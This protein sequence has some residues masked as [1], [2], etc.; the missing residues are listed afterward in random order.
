M[1]EIRIMC[2]IL[3]IYIIE[4]ARKKVENMKKYFDGVNWLLGNKDITVDYYKNSEK[5]LKKRK[6]TQVILEAVK[7]ESAEAEYYNFDYLKNEDFLQEI[8]EIIRKK[9]QRIF[10]LDLALNSSERADFQ[11]DQNKLQPQ[12]AKK[13]IEIIG[14]SSFKE[15]VVVSSRYIGIEDEYLQVLE[16][17][18]DIL[19][20]K[21]FFEFLPANVF[22]YR[23]TEKEMTTA[24]NEV[25]EE[26]FK[27]N[28]QFN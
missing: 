14:Q 28:E 5:V 21:I 23:N 7:T 11:L 20:N 1:E 3:K 27:K 4:D 10:I 15:V 9:E 17:D 24:V 2:K 22:T 16:I 6:Y 19:Q 25:L 13:V 12:N 18:R 8:E 26:I